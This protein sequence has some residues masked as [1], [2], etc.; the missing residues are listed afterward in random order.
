MHGFVNRDISWAGNEELSKVMSV[1]FAA[2]RNTA[3]DFDGDKLEY[4]IL[5]NQESHLSA[6]ES[7]RGIQTRSELSLKE[8]KERIKLFTGR[9]DGKKQ[10]FNLSEE[11]LTKTVEQIFAQDK[12]SMAA[13]FMTKAYTGSLN[14]GALGIK[15]E[16]HKSLM[17]KKLSQN[18]LE[19]ALIFINSMPSLFT[20]QQAISSK[21]LSNYIG[22]D[23]ESSLTPVESMINNIGKLNEKEVMNMIKETGSVHPSIIAHLA[24]VS[25][26]PGEKA[27]YS[28]ALDLAETILGYQ[29][30]YSKVTREQLEKHKG[31]L[32]GSRSETSWSSFVDDI[33]KRQEGRIAINETSWAKK[34]GL[35]D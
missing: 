25:S 21:H 32:Q 14:I 6:V 5:H 12:A 28:N 1:A 22:K 19:D 26:T 16:L 23:I 17:D 33:I 4:F 9:P 35:T 8:A 34:N 2:A 11:E 15:G 13:A 29:T 7:I 18:E 20:E 27:S 3:G 24:K 10:I 31:F 30:G